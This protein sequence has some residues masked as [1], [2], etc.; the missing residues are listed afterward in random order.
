MGLNEHF[1]NLMIGLKEQGHLNGLRV[2]ELGA[3]QLSDAFLRDRA[4]Q[5]KLAALYGKSSDQLPRLP[6]SMEGKLPGE[7][8][9]SRTF[10][11]ALGYEY[12]CV[13]IDGTPQALELDLNYD[14]VPKANRGRYDLVTNFGTTEHVINQLNAFKIIHDL[15]AQGGVMIHELPTQGLIDHG[16]VA[17]NPKFFRSIAQYNEYETLFF[18]F[19][20]TEIRSAMPPG[21]ILEIENYISTIGRPLFGIS[22]AVLFVAHRKTRDAEFIPPLDMPTG[23]KPPSAVLGER[24]RPAFQQRSAY[25]RL[26][27][28]V[29]MMILQ[30]KIN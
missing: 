21:L 14:E 1:L 7:E 17:Y 4:E 2:M 19:R 10:F 5:E 15:T 23:A 24:Y 29:A 16:L 25:R 8:P 26:L 3:Q 12:A 9:H 28:R 6:A 18:D 13:D 22:E 27:R 20:W 11:E 30:G